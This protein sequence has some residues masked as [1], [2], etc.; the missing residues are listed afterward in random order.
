M[1]KFVTREN[2]RHCRDQLNLETDPKTRAALRRILVEEED[3]LGANLQLLADVDHEIKKGE[4][5]I[6]KQT[7]L[8]TT[9][10]RDGH[11]GIA[12][13]KVLLDALIDS[14]DF[15]PRLS[16]EAPDQD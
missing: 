11:D 4:V 2:I 1:D 15:A 5:L 9:L 10:E 13:A 16:P 8:V 3:K 6:S 7:V 12:Q 14:Q